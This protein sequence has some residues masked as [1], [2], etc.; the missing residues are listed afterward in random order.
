[1]CL[2]LKVSKHLSDTVTPLLERT[3]GSSSNTLTSK[4]CMLVLNFGF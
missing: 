1:M 4:F 2:C 3:E